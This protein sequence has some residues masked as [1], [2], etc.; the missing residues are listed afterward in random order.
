[1][2][3]F[4]DH[5]KQAQH[6][7]KFLEN[8]NAGNYD[9]VDWQVTTCFYTA[10]HLVISLRGS[11]LHQNYAGVALFDQASAAVVV[12]LADRKVSGNEGKRVRVH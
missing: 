6:N 5:V 2:P 1:M 3:Q 4:E 12:D 7:L 9:C 11:R 10:L 8:I